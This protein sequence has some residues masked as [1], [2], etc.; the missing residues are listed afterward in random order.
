MTVKFLFLVNKQGQTRIAKYFTEH[1][2]VEEKRALEAEIVRKCLARTDKQV[3]G[4]RAVCAFC[5]AMP[6]CVCSYA[7]CS[8]LAQRYTAAPTNARAGAAGSLGSASSQRDCKQ[9]HTKRI[10]ASTHAHTTPHKQCSFYE[11]GQH[12]II[13]RRYASL[14]FIVGVDE[15]EVRG[16]LHAAVL[17]THE[18]MHRESTPCNR[19]ETPRNIYTTNII[20]T[21][22]NELEMLEFIHCFVEVLDKHFGQVRARRAG[23]RLSFGLRIVRVSVFFVLL[24]SWLPLSKPNNTPPCPP[25]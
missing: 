24:S 19:K 9:A 15:E 8:F 3:G 12:K 23:W 10:N 21:T 1:L 16:V 25:P 5:A 18:A 20:Q 2:G 13:Y 14:F 6:R 11:H 7:A 17:R 22:Q 4:A